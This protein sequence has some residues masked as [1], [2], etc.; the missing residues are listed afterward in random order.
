VLPTLFFCFLQFTSDPI[1]PS[2][3]AKLQAESRTASFERVQAQEKDLL[4]REFE[5]DFNQLVNAIKSFSD[6]YNQ[7]QGSA[8]PAEKAR[9]LSRA[10]RKL[11]HDRQLGAGKN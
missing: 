10:M 7:S 2:E 1:R 8:W 4:R 9:A 5:K 6:A 11:E 3:Q